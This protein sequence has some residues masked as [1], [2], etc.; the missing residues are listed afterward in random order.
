MADVLV[1][2]KCMLTV[3][4][5]AVADRVRDRL[6]NLKDDMDEDYV[7]TKAMFQAVRLCDALG[8]REVADALEALI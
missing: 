8:L 7:R 3:E 1:S 6:T 5:I 2:D 4:Q